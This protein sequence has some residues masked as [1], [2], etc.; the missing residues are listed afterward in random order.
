[1]H[2]CANDSCCVLRGLFR[3]EW[4][5]RAYSVGGSNSGELKAEKKRKKSQ[6]KTRKRKKSGKNEQKRKKCHVLVQK[7][8]QNFT[9][10]TNTSFN[11]KMG[12]I[13]RGKIPVSK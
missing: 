6:E 11:V 5:R 3:R 9:P 10:D 1:M 12:K 7:N 2:T 13:L 8:V 4:L